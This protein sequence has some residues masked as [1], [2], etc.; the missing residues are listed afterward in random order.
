MTGEFYKLFA[1]DLAPFLLKM[2]NE[3]VNN[4][5]L[6]PP[7]TQGLITLIPKPKKDLFSLD[8]WRP[9]SLLNNDYKLFALIFAKRLKSVLDSITKESGFMRN[10][11]ITNNIRLVLDILDYPEF[12]IDNGFILFLDFCKALDSVEHQFIFNSLIK[13]GFG[14]FFTNAIKTLY[15]NFNSS[16]KLFG[17]TSSRFNLSRGIRQGCPVSPYLFLIISQPLANHI[18]A[19]TIKGMSIIDRELIITQ[20]ADDTTLFLRNENQIPVAINVIE[21]FSKASGVY[22]NVKKCELM[23]VKECSVP[24]YCNIPVK[25][26]VNRNQ[27]N[28]SLLNFNHVI[29]NTQRKLNQWLLRDL[30]LKGRVLISKAEGISRLTYTA[31]ALQ[32]DDKISKEIDKMLFNFAW[33]NRIHYIR[34]YFNELV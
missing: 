13:F 30:S 16:I 21:E 26:E 34:N 6:P 31:M 17:G 4:Q 22:L 28:K 33:K 27:Q 8:N 7:L 9:I 25:T 29:Q 5:C 15:K 23:A 14:N 2:F 11:H 3:S 1:D 18:K 10:R 20:L 19:S 12:N 24:S 32:V